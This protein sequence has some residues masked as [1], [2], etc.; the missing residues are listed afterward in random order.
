M[1]F[2]SKW[3][4]VLLFL[5]NLL[6]MLCCLG[7]AITAVLISTSYLHDGQVETMLTIP[8]VAMALFGLVLIE[9]VFVSSGTFLGQKN[10]DK[11]TSASKCMML[12]IPVV[13]LLDILVA[14]AVY[15]SSNHITEH[16]RDNLLESIRGYNP[17]QGNRWHYLQEQ[18]HCCGVNGYMDWTQSTVMNKTFAVPDSCCIFSDIKP[19]VSIANLIFSNSEVESLKRSTYEQEGSK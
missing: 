10:K 6:V 5:G 17:E 4:R 12:G 7:L 19:L 8:I 11:I 14:I 18:F 9:F 15:A 2:L 3:F 13:I 16:M 1:E